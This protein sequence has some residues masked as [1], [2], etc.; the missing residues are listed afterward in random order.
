MS[1][2]FLM[3]FI[4]K[5][6]IQSN[7]LSNYFYTL[8]NVPC[9]CCPLL[10]ALLLVDSCRR[11]SQWQERICHYRDSTDADSRNANLAL[12]CNVEWV[13]Q[14]DLVDHTSPDLTFVPYVWAAV[15]LTTAIKTA[16]FWLT[17]GF[18]L[19]WVEVSTERR[20][21]AHLLWYNNY[22]QRHLET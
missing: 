4:P 19:L 14:V 8:F 13:R 16:E 20:H 7:L 10:W 2:C 9:G 18:A 3:S 12:L 15:F 22:L 6:T 1:V 5:H 17:P 21:N 11:A